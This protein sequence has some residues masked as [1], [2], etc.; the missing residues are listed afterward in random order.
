[1]KTLL[2]L[3]ILGTSHSHSHPKDELEPDKI[4]LRKMP[5]G[6]SLTVQGTN[7]RGFTFDEYKELAHIYTD[8]MQWGQKIP[9]L[10]NQ[11]D[12]ATLLSENQTRQIVF[13]AKDHKLL[14][15]ENTKLFEQWKQENRLRHEAENRPWYG[16]WVAWGVAAAVTVAAATLTG[17]LI[18]KD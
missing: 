4:E 17:V 13:M 2:L 6:T 16:N 5:K 9:L 7:Y 11:I 8:Y 3:L 12:Q 14:M 15:D 10:Q 18:A 1:M